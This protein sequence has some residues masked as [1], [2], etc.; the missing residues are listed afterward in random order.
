MTTGQLSIA[1]PSLRLSSQMILGGMTLA[2]K[3]R[4]QDGHTISQDGVLSSMSGERPWRGRPSYTCSVLWLTSASRQG[5]EIGNQVRS[6]GEHLLIPVA[7][8]G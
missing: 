5:L 7:S 1:H 6:L 8:M 2:I 4:Q 3:A